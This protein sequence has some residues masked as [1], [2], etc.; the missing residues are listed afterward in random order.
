[1]KE[2]LAKLQIDE[3]YYGAFGKQWM[4]NSDIIT[5]LNDP[6]N[7][8]KAKEI[9][10]PM[11]IGRYFHTAL[12][13]PEKLISS[14]FNTISSSSRN[15]KIYKDALNESGKTILM[16]DKEKEDIDCAISVMR[17]NLEFYDA[18]YEDGNQYEVPA[19]Q[20]ILGAQWK[21]KADII[22][23]DKLIDIKT[24][25]NIKD[26]KYSARK[27]NYD[28]QAYIYQQLFDKPLV[29]YVIDKVSLQLGIFYP[30][31][32]FLMNGKEK[33]ERAIEVHST[34]FKEGAKSDINDYIHKETL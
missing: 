6:K 23:P 22:T 15:T 7:F 16:L 26:F 2:I 13:E 34:F 17:S 1:M 33:V 27:Y 14:E 9:T 31:D 11:L 3:H 4:S 25:S 19:V 10:K 21:G 18:L 29:F 8:G 32:H 12:L 28:S 20:E 5:L 30:S 24:T